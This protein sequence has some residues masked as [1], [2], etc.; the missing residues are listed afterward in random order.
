MINTT[1][2]YS[3]TSGS[4]VADYDKLRRVDMGN[5]GSGFCVYCVRRMKVFDFFQFGGELGA[6]H[7]AVAGTPNNFTA[8]PEKLEKCC[9]LL[10]SV[11]FSALL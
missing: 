4:S 10:H 1:L 7:E 2:C 6:T 9:V 11:A 5:V 3:A 8:A